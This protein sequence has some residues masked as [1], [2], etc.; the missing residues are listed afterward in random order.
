MLIADSA[1]SAFQNDLTTVLSGHVCDHFSALRI[2]D[3]G[4]FRNF[5]HD[6][7]TTFAMTVPLT[8]FL[9]ILCR[10][11]T[12]MTVIGQGIQSFIHFKDHIAAITTVSAVGSTIRHKQLSSEAYMTIAALT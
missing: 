8:A 3:H 12:L 5:Q 9:S 11:F 10:I 2:F 1:T 6:I 4:S 7:R